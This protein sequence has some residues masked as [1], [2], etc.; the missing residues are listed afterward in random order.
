[1]TAPGDQS[2]ANKSWKRFAGEG[3][4]RG[5][6]NSSLSSCAWMPPYSLRSEIR[7]WAVRVGG[8]FNTTRQ[9]TAATSHTR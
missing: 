1:M 3:G 7:C 4:R 9:A 6:R 2:Y 8:Q 5:G